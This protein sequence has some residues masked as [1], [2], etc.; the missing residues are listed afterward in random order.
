LDLLRALQ[1]EFG[2]GVIFITHDLSVVADVSDRV[3]VMYAGEV[4]EE[5]D[6]ISLF[7]RPRHPYTEA[8]LAST[9]HMQS[10]GGRRLELPEVD[11]IS[12]QMAGCRFAPR[13][14]YVKAAC[15]ETHPDLSIHKGR[16]ARCIRSDELVLVGT[17]DE[18]TPAA[19]GRSPVRKTVTTTGDPQESIVE[20]AGLTVTFAAGRGLL[21]RPVGRVMAADG[22]SFSLEQGQVVAIVG[23]SGSG[24]STVA[25]AIVGLT[26]YRGSIQF[27]GRERDAMRRQER[28]RMAPRLQMV[29]Q[30]PY[31]S[32][33]PSSTVGDSI[34]EPLEVHRHLNS[35]E[36]FA[37]VAELLRAVG[38]NAG[39]AGR[40]PSQL[41]GGQRQRVAIARAIALEPSVLICD[42]A[43]SS[44]D[45]STQMQVLALLE[46]L[47]AERQ[48]AYIFITHDLSLGR[49]IADRVAVM[50]FGKVV[51]EGPVETVFSQPAHPYTMGL[52]SAVPVPNPRI[53]RAR[54][55]LHIAGEL[56]SA[57]ERPAGCSFHPRCPFVM[58]V[59]RTVIPTPVPTPGDRTVSCHLNEGKGLR[60]EDVQETMLA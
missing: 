54:R 28:R 47:A 20:V 31:S 52:L 17:A 55:A 5:A 56:P 15:R 43:V 2:M 37:R 11:R 4:V 14:S 24:K 58:E 60:P 8:L 44:L 38:L 21:G 57:M 59:C 23:E 51:E 40:Y 13:C 6:A 33:D 45:V 10:R 1:A 50:Y 12:T 16:P 27:E 46:R 32:L 39:F 3:L 34:A 53:Q 26:K 22:V 25:R 29:F 35:R 42:E 49:H 9:P 19:G 7:D 30:D 18:V 36:R 41:S 48:M